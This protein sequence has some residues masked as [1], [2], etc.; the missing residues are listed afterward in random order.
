MATFGY[1]V[2]DFFTA[3]A[4][5]SRIIQTLNDTQQSHSEYQILLSDLEDLKL[6]FEELKRYSTTKDI[7]TTATEHSHK[8]VVQGLAS[9][10][11]AN[12]LSLL[13]KVQKFDR[14]LGA[15]ATTGKLKGQPRKLQW[16]FFVKHEVPSWRGHIAVM[17]ATLHI[18]MSMQ[19]R[20]EVVLPT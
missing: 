14:S 13:D 4:V 9:K 12:L 10:Y 17:I 11:N 15:K 18:L 8:N 20:L 19:A 3:I 2:G 7:G 16:A 6:V 5:L 1:S